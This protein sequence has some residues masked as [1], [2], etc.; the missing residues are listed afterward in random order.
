MVNQATKISNLTFTGGMNKDLDKSIRKGDTYLDAQNFRLVADEAGTTGILENIKG[1][2]GWDGTIAIPRTICGYTMIRNKLVVFVSD[3]TR[4]YETPPNTTNSKIYV[5]EIENGSVVGTPT[6]VYAD[7]IIKGR[8]LLSIAHPIKAVGRYEN[9]EVQKVYWVDGYNNFRWCNIADPNLTDQTVD[10]FDI[11]SKVILS[12]PS[13]IST[14]AGSLPVGAVQYAYQFYI[15][16]GSSTLISPCSDLIHLTISSDYLATTDAYKGAGTDQNS[17]KGV[18]LEIENNS[19]YNYIRL[20][21]IH[22]SDLNA[23]P[24]V[25]VFLETFINSNIDTLKFID[26]GNIIYETTY[27]EFSIFSSGL[28]K[29][30]DLAIKNDFL[31]V[32]NITEED[33]DIGDYDT[34]AYRFKKNSADCRLYHDYSGD[35][36]NDP[37]IGCVDGTDIETSTWTSY[38]SAPGSLSDDPITDIPEELDA[39]N[40]FNNLDND[41]NVTE[42]SNYPYKYQF[43][44]ATQ[45]G[46]GYNIDYGF[47]WNHFI[48]DKDIYWTTCFPT[49]QVDKAANAS[50]NNFA[51]PFKSNSIRGY[52]HDETYRWA[53]TFLDERGRRSFPRWIA[54]IRMPH[55][56]Y[57]DFFFTEIQYGVIGNNIMG[58]ALVPHFKVKN[59]PSGA[60]SY[61]IVRC[62]REIINDRNIV[63]QGILRGTVDNLGIEYSHLMDDVDF[64]QVKETNNYCIFS[65]PEINF[66]NDISF[67]ANDQLQVI[68]YTKN[69]GSTLGYPNEPYE[70]YH[71]DVTTD[72]TLHVGKIRKC[73]AVNSGEWGQAP[74]LNTVLTIKSSTIINPIDS[75]YNISGKDFKSYRGVEHSFTG[76]SLLINKTG[77]DNW[78]GNNDA[79]QSELSY[80]FLCN[81]RRN[82]WLAQYGGIT[83][84][85]R[86]R[87]VYI[88]AGLLTSD[89]G[90]NIVVNSGDTFINYFDH[91][92]GSSDLS[93]NNGTCV[94]E[95]L[96]FPVNSSYNLDL[97]HG[98]S[99]KTDYKRDNVALI[100]EYNSAGGFH[101]NYSDTKFSQIENYYLLNTVFSQENIAFKYF[102]KPVA[103]LYS[104]E[105]VFDTRIKVS[106]KKI[107]GESSDNWLKFLPNNY[108]DVDSTYGYISNIE[109]FKDRLMFWQERGFGVVSVN[110]RALIQDQSGTQLVLGTGGVL[111]RH[112]YISTKVG[113]EN[114]WGICVADDGV[115]WVN[116]ISKELVVFTGE[117]YTPLS[118]V[119]G[120]KSYM[121]SKEYINDAILVWDKQ[122]NEMLYTVYPA[123]QA[124]VNAKDYVGGL[125]WYRLVLNVDGLSV[126]KSLKIGNVYCFIEELNEPSSYI[127][128]ITCEDLF[129]EGDVIYPAFYTDKFTVC[130]SKSVGV[131]TSFYTF[132]PYIYVDIEDKF[133]SM[134]PVKNFLHEHNFWEYNK[135]YGVFYPSTLK[136]IVTE[137]Y[138]QIKVFDNILFTTKADDSYYGI[139]K[140]TITFNKLRCYNDYQNTDWVNLVLKTNLERRER[141]WSTYIPRN[142]VTVDVASNPDIFDDTILDPNQAFGERMRDNHL[143]TDLSFGTSG[144]R[145]NVSM[146][147]VKYRLSIR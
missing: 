31:F 145:F 5:F 121:S 133:L 79:A 128:I 46:S 66:G 139:D 142:A 124:I 16:N 52:M 98:N 15:H 14:I 18:Q 104:I 101:T 112:D 56:S 9:E 60:V 17:G 134:S 72:P 76:T 81:Y 107:N 102:A 58:K 123:R 25:R 96:L 26:T 129:V 118:T 77:N 37:Y 4:F 2:N 132:I 88:A 27:S 40:L 39:I 32:G 93:G 23:I 131:F 80:R 43:K 41:A 103:E 11:N 130:F 138:P 1:T 50:Y 22:Y 65:S 34:R 71:K 55:L 8:L 108:R 147:N 120:L 113:N 109:T 146:I 13:I 136:H 137:N 114:I 95:V 38:N 117:T 91:L 119:K 99:Y 45:G 62:R 7:D 21:A 12:Q 57:S 141:M 54:D 82:N 89:I 92:A 42:D 67:K 64:P 115:Y 51:S 105:N 10:K 3:C 86:S 74:F 61:Q 87:N 6:C 116:N 36:T 85:D 135:F 90:I 68:A 83:Y 100:Q 84:E 110:D 78:V 29:A 59:M 63:C 106:Q 144:T 49:I 97:R 28:F 44:S 19:D 48:L 140:F 75:L 47:S 122:N 69:I 33:F 73:Q 70:F 20:F 126:G 24:T 53:I 94:A 125:Y 127:K 111:D 35:P 30:R 143:V